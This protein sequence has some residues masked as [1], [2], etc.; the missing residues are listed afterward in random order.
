M[1]Y[2]AVQ[3][4]LKTKPSPWD[5]MLVWVVVTEVRGMWTST[6]AALSL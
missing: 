4:G 5:V 6:W 1:Q 3:Q 2:Q